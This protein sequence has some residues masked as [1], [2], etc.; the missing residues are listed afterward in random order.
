MNKALL[1]RDKSGVATF[2]VVIV[3]WCGC[4]FELHIGK[5]ILE[6]GGLSALQLPLVRL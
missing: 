3:L 2:E 6:I 4:Y 5:D 1:A